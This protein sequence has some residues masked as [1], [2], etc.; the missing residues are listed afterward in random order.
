VT[1]VVVTHD[2]AIARQ[3]DRIV[4]MRDGKVEADGPPAEVLA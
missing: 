1:V 3:T 4:A 2:A